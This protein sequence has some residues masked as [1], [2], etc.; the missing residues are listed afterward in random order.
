[1]PPEMAASTIERDIMRKNPAPARR[2]PAA[3]LLAGAVFLTLAVAAGAADDGYKLGVMD[4]L[5]IRV[6]EWQP[7]DG[8][9]KN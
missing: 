6:A 2:S 3:F 5:R 9:V 4:K 1:M 7:A 8:S